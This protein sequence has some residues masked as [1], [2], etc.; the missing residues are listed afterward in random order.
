MAKVVKSE[1][2]KVKQ[3]QMPDVFTILKIKKT[4]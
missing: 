2:E 1:H 4:Y 3:L